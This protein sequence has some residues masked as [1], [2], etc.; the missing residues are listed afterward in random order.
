VPFDIFPN[1][2]EPDHNY[3]NWPT[4]YDQ[5]LATEGHQQDIGDVWKDTHQM[6]PSFNH[7][8]NSNNLLFPAFQPPQAPWGYFGPQFINMR[9]SIEDQELPGFHL[10]G[11]NSQTH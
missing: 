9:G 3:L 10:T 4:S 1:I 6:L 7:E 2:N 11:S 8:H 5:F